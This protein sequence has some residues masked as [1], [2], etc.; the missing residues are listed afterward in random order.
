M[1][2]WT[3]L[4][5]ALVILATAVIATAEEEEKRVVPTMREQVYENLSNAQGA[6]EKDDFDRA[7]DLLRDVEKIDDLNGYER[8]QL[9]SAYGYIYFVQEKYT[10]SVGAYEQ[11][12]V[13]ENLPDVL[14][15]TTLYTLAQLEFQ[16]E[17]YEE[18]IAH[19]KRWLTKAVSPKPE[20]YVLLGQGYYQLERYDEAVP[21]VESAIDA[22][23][24]RDLPVKE[25]WYGLLRALYHE[26]GDQ[27]NLIEVLEILVTQFPSKDYWTH[28]ASV[29][30]EMEDARQLAVHEL[31]YAQGYLDDSGPELLLLSQL[32][33]QA[34]VPYRAA[35]I[36]SQGLDRG[37]IERTAQHYRLLSQ[38]WMLAREDEKAVE[39]LTQAAALTDDGE[40]YAR[41]AMTYANLDAWDKTVEAARRA[42]R[43]GIRDP[44]DLQVTL[45][46]ALFQLE[47]FDEAKDAFRQA[48]KAP[49]SRATATKWINYI[50][51]EQKRLRE[52]HDSLE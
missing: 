45:G 51:T 16:Q 14:L 20:A 42:L 44:H 36:L 12:L 47:R 46:M 7:F 2:R 6:A 30:G 5:V 22:A 27:E 43:S 11:V 19:L 31:A 24:Q 39:A 1:R 15:T 49:E 52:L 21:A 50:D 10:E 25:S 41:L 26:L 38:A 17:N 4:S 32:L 37:V 33:L 34:Q 35:A 48:Q 23:R 29:Y 13:Q 18:G 8:A 40:V 9:Y 28:L 3:G